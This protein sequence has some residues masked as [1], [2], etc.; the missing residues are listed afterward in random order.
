VSSCYP[1]H[2]TPLPPVAKLP[3]FSWI[4]N[5]AAALLGRHGAVTR[6]A[7]LSG[8]S[9]QTVYDHAHK[10][11][12]AVQQTCSP[13]PSREALLQEVRQLRA[14]NQH[15]WEWLGE[16]LEVP[17]EKQH[18]FAGAAAALGLS[19]EQTRSLLAILVPPAR[20]PSRATLGRWVRQLARRAGAVLAVLDRACQRLV[21]CLC[22]DEIFFRRRPVLMGIEPHS[23]AWVLGR[24]AADRSGATW[25]Q[26]LA[27]W[28]RVEDVA[29]DGGSGLERGLTLA[30][31]KRRD[32]AASPAHA[33]PLR[34]RLD[35]FHTRREGER[36]LRLEWQQAEGAWEAAETV[37]RAKR[38]RGRRGADRRGFNRR[39]ARL[40]KKAG[41]ALERAERREQAWRRAVTA[42]A[43]FRPDGQLN[44]RAWA[45]AT[46]QAAV[47]E[48]PGPRWA[49]T[50]RLLVDERSLTFLD[51]LHEDLAAAEPRSEVRAALAARWQR[52][53]TGPAPPEPA[54]GSAWAVLRPVLDGALQ[55]RLGA[56]AADCYRRVARVLRRV[57]RASSAVECVNSVVRMHQARHRNLTQPLLDLKRLY[58]NSRPFVSGQRRRGCP[59]EHLGLA[60]PSYDP[61]TLLQ[62]D[63]EELEQQLS[64][65]RIAA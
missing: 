53:R 36:A 44:D 40:W 54:A 58:W 26:A 63:P 49:K 39:L 32:E 43:V 42:L 16:A 35:T 4:G 61:W 62:M 52:R 60:L 37:E 11:V 50:R 18:H 20:C 29:A 8:C 34:V 14:E 59:Y 31:Q 41:A 56:G 46:V 7:L 6:Q 45:T 1:V 64:T 47:A 38:R 22:L 27:A 23:L 3:L 13:G 25:A 19:L 33:A 5:A 12:Q 17:P 57:V 55:A 10:V 21:G 65:P 24:R 48:L 28:P 9:R 30:A 2:A 15:L 51:R